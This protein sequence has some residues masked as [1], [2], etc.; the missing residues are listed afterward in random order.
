[1]LNVE[2]LIPFVAPFFAA[3]FGAFFAFLGKAR[4][5]RKRARR[6]ATQGVIDEF[7]SSSFLKHRI[8]VSQ[9]REKVI[10]GEVSIDSIAGGYWYPGKINS[11]GGEM[12]G[13]FNEHQ[14]LEAYKGF[15]VRLASSDAERLLDRKAIR[16]ALK[17]SY[18]WHADLVNHVANR[19]RKQVKDS[20]IA[21]LPGWV[22]SVDRVNKIMDYNWAKKG[23][24]DLENSTTE[25]WMKLIKH[26]ETGDSALTVEEVSRKSI[27]E[28]KV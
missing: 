24:I 21:E 6:E 19:V 3:F 22:S 9:L 26:D 1:M 11:Y 15:L 18:F 23:V 13:E 4:I 8:A 10:N 28:T 7:F 12:H 5:D 25:E 14:H 16:T 17:T 20:A 27:R 2:L